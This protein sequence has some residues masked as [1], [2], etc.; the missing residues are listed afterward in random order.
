MELYD[1][2]YIIPYLKKNC[3]LD[4]LVSDSRVLAQTWLKGKMQPNEYKKVK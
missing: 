1:N 2:L 4:L 3:Q